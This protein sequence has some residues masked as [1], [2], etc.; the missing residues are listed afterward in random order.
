MDGNED[1]VGAELTQ[2]REKANLAQF[3]YSAPGDRENRFLA[4][5]VEA[6]VQ[7]ISQRALSIALPHLLRHG[8]PGRGRY[9]GNGP[10]QRYPRGDRR[11]KE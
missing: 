11:G 3:R 10:G 6:W 2:L 1:S 9:C 7:A 4:L 8:Q 5:A